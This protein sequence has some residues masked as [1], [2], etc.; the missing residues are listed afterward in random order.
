MFSSDPTMPIT[1]FLDLSVTTGGSIANDA[2]AAL[3]NPFRSELH[4]D[5]PARYDETCVVRHS[6]AAQATVEVLSSHVSL[7]H[8]PGIGHLACHF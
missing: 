4:P 1:G 3:P 7:Q 2:A 5:G 8:A 6:A